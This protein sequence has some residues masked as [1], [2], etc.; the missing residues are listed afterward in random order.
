MKIAVL[1]DIHGNLEAFQAVLDAIEHFR[2]DT[3][4]SLGDNIGYGPDSEA[5]VALIRARKIASVLG[6][7]EMAV[8]NKNNLAWFNPVAQNALAIAQSQLSDASLAWINQLPRYIILAG[9]RFVHG[10][11]PDSA[12]LYLFQLPENR[13]IRKLAQSEEPICFAGHTHELEI[14]SWDGTR[15]EKQ[16]PGPGRYC[17]EP[18]QKYIINAGSVGQPR[19]G[20]AGAKFVLY[21]T[22]TQELTVRAVAY[23]FEKTQEKIIAAGIPRMYADRLAAGADPSKFKGTNQ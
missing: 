11:P 19:D 5:V 7:H 14:I 18:D 21:D 12:F 10:V 8:K 15:L 17:L 22:G 23:P 6:N 9:L 1:S 4:I 13:L 3:V 20:S 2:I 16:T